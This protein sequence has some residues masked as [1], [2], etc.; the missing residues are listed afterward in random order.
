MQAHTSSKAPS[1]FPHLPPTCVHRQHVLGKPLPLAQLLHL[2]K[3]V[4]EGCQALHGADLLH[5]DLKVSNILLRTRRSLASEV[6]SAA[7]L[8]AVVV[9]LGIAIR[10][11]GERGWQAGTSALGSLGSMAPEVFARTGA[12]GEWRQWGVGRRGKGGGRLQEQ[13]PLVC[14]GM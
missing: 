2:L 14:T 7:A 10:R 3:D 8:E 6:G 5:M 1:T 12:T 11:D 4:A 9:D 13:G